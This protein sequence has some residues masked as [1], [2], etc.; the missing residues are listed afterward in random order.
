MAPVD[1]A[2]SKLSQS[3]PSTWS[4]CQLA[5]I[6]A[7]QGRSGPRIKAQVSK[8][9]TQYT[10]YFALFKK[11][12]IYFLKNMALV[13]GPLADNEGDPCSKVIIRHFLFF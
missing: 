2:G 4:R 3:K 11:Q 13:L 8:F 10:C 7:F 12:K 1:D 6:S 9:E 5:Q